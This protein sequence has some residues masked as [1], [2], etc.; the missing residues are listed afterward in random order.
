MGGK[1]PG[2]GGD[3]HGHAKPGACLL[4][5]KVYIQPYYITF[6]HMYKITNVLYMD[7]FKMLIFK[8]EGRGE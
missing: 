6:C 1:N 4:S 3:K 8:E 7:T 5:A 2:Q